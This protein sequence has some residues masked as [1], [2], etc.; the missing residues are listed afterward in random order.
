MGLGTQDPAGEER[1]RP[2]RSSAGEILV[3]LTET[4]R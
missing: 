1:T 3:K 4:T 2:L